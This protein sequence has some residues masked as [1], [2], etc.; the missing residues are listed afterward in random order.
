MKINLE[1]GCYSMQ[2]LRVLHKWAEMN[3]SERV[4]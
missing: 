4:S 2:Q 1:Q 3:I